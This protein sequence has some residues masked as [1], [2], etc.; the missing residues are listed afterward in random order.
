MNA[1][2]DETATSVWLDRQGAV[3]PLAGVRVVDLSRV[4]A[5][6]L[7]SQMLSDH[8]ADVIKVEPPFGDESRQL[9]P[10]FDNEGNAAYFSALNRG[11]RAITLDLASEAERKALFSLLEHADVLLENFVPGTMRKWGLDYETHLKPRFPRL[12]YCTISGFGDSG[13]LGGLPG[14][15][16]VLQAMCGLMSINGDQDAG[17]TRIGIPLV[18]HL[19][20]YTAMSGILMALYE[21]A[22]THQGQKVEAA[23]F[24][25][26][27]SLLVPQ[28]AN[29]MHS[30]KTLARMGCAHPNIAPY[31]R[32]DTLDGP[33]FLGVVND[34]QFR[35]L[36]KCLDIDDLAS[37]PEF[38]TNSARVANR[39]RLYDV[40][41]RRF[42]RCG[43]DQLCSTLM[44]HGI[45]A[46]P[47]N[48]VPEA[49]GHPHARHRNMV[50]ESAQYKGLGSPMKL[51][52]VNVGAQ[53]KPPA[54]GEHNEQI[55]PLL[56]IDV[57]Q[58]EDV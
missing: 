19:T 14:Y 9:G 25:A 52:S 53:R 36:C 31:D 13:P 49:L 28:A 39:D 35:K 34:S 58:S 3:G 54:L 22:R 37:M 21:R 43:R 50:V 33:I 29:W 1:G 6:P 7:C 45:P 16:A 32:F 40:L 55:K 23:L 11:K 38:K 57:C 20:A 44:Q 4:L 12:V 10:P 27:L 51:H 30:G 5:G 46:G 17:P 42:E 8:G 24:D 26:A 48:T 18:D 56:G 47:V 2:T 41:R 15:D